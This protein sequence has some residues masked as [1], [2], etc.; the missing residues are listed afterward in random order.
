M[1]NRSIEEA[2]RPNKH[3]YPLCYGHAGCV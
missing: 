3:I 2:S 1:S